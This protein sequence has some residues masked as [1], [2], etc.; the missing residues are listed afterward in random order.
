MGYLEWV[1]VILLGSGRILVG[2]GQWVVGGAKPQ[3]V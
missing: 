1:L 2:S 3:A